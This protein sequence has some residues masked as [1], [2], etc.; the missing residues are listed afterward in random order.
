MELQTTGA[1]APAA[2]GAQPETTVENA[3]A[4]TAQPS[5]ADEQ[6][7]ASA[8]EETGAESGD[9]AAAAPPRKKPGVHNR[10]DELTRQKHDAIRDRDYWR[11]KA[12]ELSSKNTD[13][14]DYDDQLVTKV[15]V[16]TARD[17]AET[18]DITAQR[19]VQRQFEILENEARARWP[20]YDAV[21]RG[22]V[23]ITQEMADIIAE[24]EMG[25]DVAY[26][27]GKNPGEAW[28]LAQLSDKRL[29]K[30]MGKLEARLSQP[31]P[32]PK[33]PPAPVQPVS[34]IAAGGSQDPGTMSMSEYAAWRKAN[35]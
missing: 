9:D 21:S 14:M 17:R 4:T 3:E 11:Q 26:H 28:Q 24:S 23:P 18:A 1:E 33:Q 27:L 29:A 22:P 13:A 6:G 10:I 25:P 20:D 5:E 19:A 31:K 34:G 16:A 35:P 15:Q 32:L 8:T 30:E 2:D 7:A 12:E